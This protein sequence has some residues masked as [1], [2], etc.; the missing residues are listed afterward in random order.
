[1]IR[2]F[3]KTPLSATAF[4][5]SLARNDINVGVA[6]FIF[7]PPFSQSLKGKL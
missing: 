1:V 7:C 5:G 6:V 2:G 4:A 3:P